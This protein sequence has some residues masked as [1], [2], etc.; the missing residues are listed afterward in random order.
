MHRP[1]HPRA[2]QHPPSVTSPPSTPLSTNLS[3][4]LS[5]NASAFVPAKKVPIKVKNAS[6]QEVTLD[7][8]KRRTQLATVPPLPPS[9]ASV[10]KDSKRQLIRIE[11]QEQK[12]KRL[13]E[14]GAK[15]RESHDKSESSEALVRANEA[16]ARREIEEQERR[17][18]Q[19]CNRQTTINTNPWKRP[20]PLNFQTTI[21]SDI[22]PLPPSAFATARY[23][24]DLNCITYPQGIKSPKLELNVNTQKGKFR[25]DFEIHIIMP[26][27]LNVILSQ[28]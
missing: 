17:E 3:T 22:A 18:E 8:L 27:F 24:E 13:A 10:K 9:P 7:T 20:G 2:P 5:A 15:E 21:N 28:L 14:E 25:Y 6:G 19:A 16:T 11:S 4:P 12:E 23:I 1:P 26:L